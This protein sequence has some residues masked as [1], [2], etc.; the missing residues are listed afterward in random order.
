[1][2]SKLQCTNFYKLSRCCIEYSRLVLVTSHDDITMSVSKWSDPDQL[3]LHWTVHRLESHNLTVTKAVNTA[4]WQL[5][6]RPL[7]TTDSNCCKPE[8]TTTPN[9]QITFTDTKQYLTACHWLTKSYLPSPLRPPL[10]QKYSATRPNWPCS[11]AP[12]QQSHHTSQST[13]CLKVTDIS[14]Q[15]RYIPR[16]SCCCCTLSFNKPTTLNT[17]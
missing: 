5:I 13:V 3:Y 14:F 12:V 15:Q 16:S 7:M 10:A 4:Q 17:W 2:N 1:M 11:A 6:T 9:Q 8:M